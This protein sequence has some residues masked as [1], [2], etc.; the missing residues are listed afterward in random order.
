MKMSR[1]KQENSQRSRMAQEAA[2]L[3]EQ[4]GIRDFRI[5]KTKAADRLG[6]D[7]RYAAQPKN[8]EIEMALAERLRLFGGDAQQHRLRHLREQAIHAMRLFAQFKPRLVG[9][10][11]TGLVTA[12]SDVQLHVFADH[13]ETFDLFLDGQ[14]I[15]FDL[16]ERR[17][18][19]GGQQ[20]H[21]YPAFQ[22]A[23][24]E[25]GFEAVLFPLV[26]LRQSPRSLVDGAPMRRASTADVEATLAGC[27]RAD[28]VAAR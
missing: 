10:V 23:A 3:I 25:V 19:F 16:V 15:P 26:G 12:H 8:T 27:T 2:R 7:I 6:I 9:D 1:I 14:G 4:Q 5:A 22:F 28:E 20:Y 18:R 24:G 17:F 11:L 13:S 21:Y